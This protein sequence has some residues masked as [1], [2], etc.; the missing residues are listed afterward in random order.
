MMS[1]PLCVKHCVR[2]FYI[3]LPSWKQPY[4]KWLFSASHGCHA[5][6]RQEN[7]AICNAKARLLPLCDEVT[8]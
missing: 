5:H 1:Y 8:L 4:E 3:C 6:S 2:T 7:R